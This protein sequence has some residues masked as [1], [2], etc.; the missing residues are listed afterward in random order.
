MLWA[1][2]PSALE[3]LAIWADLGGLR[4]PLQALGP[5]LLGAGQIELWLGGFLLPASWLRWH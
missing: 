3:L 1:L 5:P 4:A 2:A